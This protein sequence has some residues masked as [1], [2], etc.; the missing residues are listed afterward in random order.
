[1]LVQDVK[2]ESAIDQIKIQPLRLALCLLQVMGSALWLKAREKKMPTNDEREEEKDEKEEKE[3]D[4]EYD[5]DFDKPSKKDMI[6]VKSLFERL[7]E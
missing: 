7:Q 6:K 4:D 5:P 3:D 1:V 2:K